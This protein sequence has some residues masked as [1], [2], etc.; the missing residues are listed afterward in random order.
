VASPTLQDTYG[1]LRRRRHNQGTRQNRAILH[2]KAVALRPFFS[3]ITLGS[4]VFFDDLRE[5]ATSSNDVAQCRI[6][7]SLARLLRMRKQTLENQALTPSHFFLSV[8]G[9][10]NLPSTL[11]WIPSS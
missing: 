11:E 3:K 10:I 2:S 5:Q 4:G 8:Y 1:I 7:G 9:Y 6:Y